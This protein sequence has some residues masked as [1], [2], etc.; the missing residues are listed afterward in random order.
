MKNQK[1]FTLIELLVVVAIIGI[2]SGIAFVSISRARQSAY[3]A[4]IRSELSQIRSNAEQFYYGSGDG[5]YHGYHDSSGWRRIQG[6]I[7]GCSI[8]ILEQDSNMRSVS[9]DYDDGD[10]FESYQLYIDGATDANPDG[11]QY[12]QSYAAWAPL[13][14]EVYE[15]HGDDEEHTVFYCVDSD[16]S[17][18]EYYLDPDNGIS[19]DEA[20]CQDVFG[21]DFEL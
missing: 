18:G 13:C 15:D 10:D 6:E 16:G 8:A 5:S 4:Q 14:G 19:N 2:L 21:E 20:N 12:A 17:A 11:D 7:P 3:D 9:A 1:G